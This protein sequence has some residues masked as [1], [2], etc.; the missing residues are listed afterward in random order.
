MSPYRINFSILCTIQYSCH[1]PCSLFLPRNENRFK[2]LL[3]PILPNTGSTTLIRWLYICLP[4]SLSTRSRIQ[5]CAPVVGG[6][7]FEA[8][9]PW[10]LRELAESGLRIHSYFNSQA[11]QSF[12]PPSK[13]NL[14]L[15][16]LSTV[17][18]GSHI[19]LPAG[20]TQVLLSVSILNSL[21]GMTPRWRLP[22]GFRC[23]LPYC[24]FC[25]A[26][27]GSRVLNWLSGI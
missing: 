15:P 4:S 6:T 12:I 8:Y 24:S 22:A 27:L 18:S 1:C 21:A 25:S 3:V 11:R 5:A 26:N 19:S 14:R 7:V 13:N 9:R 16:C 20:Q 10:P 2:R 17:S 23:R